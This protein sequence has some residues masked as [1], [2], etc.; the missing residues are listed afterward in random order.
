MSIRAL[1][2]WRIAYLLETVV[3]VGVRRQ[4]VLWRGSLL[5]GVVLWGAHDAA[6]GRWR[7][8]AADVVALAAQLI[9]GVPARAVASLAIAYTVAAPENDPSPHLWSGWLARKRVRNSR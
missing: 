6:H 9:G 4:S 3:Y 1:N 5:L 7:T 8:L 2:R